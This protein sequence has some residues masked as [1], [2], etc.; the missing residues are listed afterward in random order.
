MHCRRGTLHPVRTMAKTITK[1]ASAKKVAARPAKT[2]ARGKSAS[3]KATS[4]RSSMKG[5]V[6]AKR[7]AS[8]KA[9]SRTRASA[10]PRPSGKG[11][12]A[13]QIAALKARLIEERLRLRGRL[14]YLEDDDETSDASNVGDIADAATY[15][16]SRELRRGLQL[17]EMEQLRLVEAALTRIDEGTFGKCTGCGQPIEFARLEVLP[18]APTC[19]ACKQKEERGQSPR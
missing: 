9:G 18:Q 7:V 5:A 1:K 12:T 17:A 8:A 16:E 11:L 10:P 2:A 3:A 14:G 4:S 13:S 19:I 6:S 15:F